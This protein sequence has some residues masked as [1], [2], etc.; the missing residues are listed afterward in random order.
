MAVSSGV[1]FGCE[2][3]SRTGPELVIGVVRPSA[4]GLLGLRKVRPVHM[5]CCP[6]SSGEGI[7]SCLQ[8]LVQRRVEIARFDF[9]PLQRRY[10]AGNT[11][12]Q[13][14]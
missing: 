12:L 11:I 5:Q 2:R 3:Q 4:A 7:L 13:A 1:Q 8:F 6:S 10:Q 14:I 9:T